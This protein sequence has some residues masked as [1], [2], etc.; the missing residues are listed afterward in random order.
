MLILGVAAVLIAS[1]IAWWWS[2]PGQLWWLRYKVDRYIPPLVDRPGGWDPLYAEHIVEWHLDPQVTRLIARDVVR[3]YARR[4]P[5]DT[6]MAQQLRLR[7]RMEREISIPQP[8]GWFFD[9]RTFTPWEEGDDILLIRLLPPDQHAV[10]ARLCREELGTE[11]EIIPVEKVIV[12]P[13]DLLGNLTR[14]TSNDRREAK[15]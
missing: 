1:V 14:A 7:D 2:T 8:F 10:L 3:W 9:Q 6:S 13:L 11:G 4:L 5:K 12:M 15:P